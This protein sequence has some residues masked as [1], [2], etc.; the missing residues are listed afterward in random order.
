MIPAQGPLASQN[1]WH[2]CI[3]LHGVQAKS[4]PAQARCPAHDSCTSKAA[5]LAWSTAL[6]RDCFACLRD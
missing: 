2:S 6:G 1:T 5:L 4:L 3:L